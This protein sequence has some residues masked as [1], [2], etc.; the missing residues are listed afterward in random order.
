MW[1]NT[2]QVFGIACHIVSTQCVKVVLLLKE[3]A[4][5]FWV[6]ALKPSKIVEYGSFRIEW[7]KNIKRG[8][9]ICTANLQFHKGTESFGWVMVFLWVSISL[10]FDG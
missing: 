5:K 10:S 9:S 3:K 6:E 4:V 1:K 7:G 8:I 2:S